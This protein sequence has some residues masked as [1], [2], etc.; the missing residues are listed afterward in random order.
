MRILALIYFFFGSAATMATS[1]PPRAISM[2]VEETADAV[3][4][5]LNGHS[6]SD[7]EVSYELV[8]EGRST[9]RHKGRTKLTAG[10]NA[11]LSTMR[12]S[13]AEPWCIKASVTEADG[14]SYEYAKGS[15]T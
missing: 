9:S 1:Q 2:D 15:C 5:I 11:I 14:T 7:Q 3:T 6:D 10:Q 12:M 4:V 13:A 8:M